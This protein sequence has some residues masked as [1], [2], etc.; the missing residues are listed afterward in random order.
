MKTAV[1]TGASGFI[2]THLVKIL[3]KKK[4]CVT[5]FCRKNSLNLN[6]L[7][8]E[9]SV[10]FDWDDFNK[11]PKPD[12]FYHLAWDAPSG[13]GRADAIL[14]SESITATITALQNAAPAKFI[15]LGTV[16]ERFAEKVINS[17]EFSTPN[18]YILAKHAAHKLSSQL[19]YKLN[20]DYIWSQVCHPIGPFI[21]PEQLMAYTVSSLLSGNVPSFGS[22]TTIFDIIAVEDVAYGLYLL[23]KNKLPRR[24]YYIG[25]GNPRPL[26]TYLEETRRILGVDTPL[27][28]D[29]RPD[30]GLVFDESWFDISQL[31]EDT[32][33]IP[34]LSFEQV[35]RRFIV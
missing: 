32:G 17:C 11:F 23:G 18:F 8:K 29:Q 14:Q 9:V 30:D 25:S 2:G 16:Y 26:R 24:E 20:C 27:L 13:P 21:K 5:A 1:V 10:I 35:V 7:P 19:A 4:M 33:F 12:V 34:R 22:A 28:F 31:T 15:A 6:R 3:L